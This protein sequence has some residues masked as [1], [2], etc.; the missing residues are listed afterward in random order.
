LIFG[1]WS[2][3]GEKKFKVQSSRFKVQG[4]RLKVGLCERVAGTKGNQRGYTERRD[5]EGAEKRKE[6]E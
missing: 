4:S 1:R 2:E 5:A 3:G 6:A